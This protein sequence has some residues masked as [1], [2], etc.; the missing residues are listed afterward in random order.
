MRNTALTV[1]D[2]ECLEVRTLLP[3]APASTASV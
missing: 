3:A 1:D 2:T